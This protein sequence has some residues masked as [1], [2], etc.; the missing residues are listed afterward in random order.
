VL[1]LLHSQ[2][3]RHFVTQLILGAR[4]K[5]RSPV[6]FGLLVLGVSAMA[7][8]DRSDS[9]EFIK[10]SVEAVQLQAAGHSAWGFGNESEWAIDQELGEIQF[11]F[12]D[13][14]V[15][16]A[17]VQIIGTY[18]PHAETFLWSWDHPSI[19]GK[20][21]IHASLVREYGRRNGIRLF[22][23][24]KV[25]CSEEDAWEFAAVAARLAEANGV[26]RGNA[27]GPWVYVTFGEVQIEKR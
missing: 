12:E 2:K 26:Y 18:D 1:Q 7:V 19:E 4:R 14:R 6:F 15:A 24:R 17:P 11:T 16:T 23:T 25:I 20:L 22:T 3:Q 9:A 5:M 27:D 13:G 10:G 21:A 8:E